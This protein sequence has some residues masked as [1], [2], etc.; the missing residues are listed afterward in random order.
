MKKKVSW[1][2]FLLIIYF[3]LSCAPQGPDPIEEDTWI[4]TA[5]ISFQDSLYN[6]NTI[7]H[8][9]DGEGL[10]VNININTARFGYSIEGDDIKLQPE[11]GA[12]QILKILE[13]KPRRLK[14]QGINGDTIDF[15]AISFPPLL[16]NIAATLA[17]HSFV[18]YSDLIEQADKDTLLFSFYP[19]G[20]MDII[21]KRAVASGNLALQ[22]VLPSLGIVKTYRWRIKRYADYLLLLIDGAEGELGFPFIGLLRSV[23]DE[24]ITFTHYFNAGIHQTYLEE[25]AMADTSLQTQFVGQWQSVGKQKD[26][27]EL[28]HAGQFTYTEGESSAQGKWQID[29]SGNILR[30]QLGEGELRMGSVDLAKGF[31]M[32]ESLADAGSMRQFEK[33]D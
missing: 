27:L 16:E 29:A 21:Q 31:I 13:R 33:Q 11:E 5:S 12:E 1:P 19:G 6:P 4:A 15:L 25:V 8:L 7:L 9:R 23:D 26:R 3:G 24:K 20:E 17:D 28:D 32:L 22:S 10:L 14:I 2:I 18:V 30:L